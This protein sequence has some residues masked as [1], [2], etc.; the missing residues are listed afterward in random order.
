MNGFR[1]SLTKET[2]VIVQGISG[3]HGSFHAERM[4][5][6]GTNIIAGVD[7][8]HGGTKVSGVPVFGS[9]EDALSSAGKAQWSVVFVP[10]PFAKPACLEGLQA[11]L[12]L[13]IVTEGIPIHDTLAIAQE[14]EALGRRVI[15]PNCPG[16]AVPGEASLGVIPAKALKLGGVGVV[17][18]SGTLTYEIT[19]LLS[20]AGLGQRLLVGLGGDAVPCTSFEPI[21]EWMERDESVDSIV[22]IGEIG[23]D[24]EE[25]AADYIRARVTKPVA[26]YIAGSHAPLGTRMGHAGAIAS[27]G[28]GSAASKVAAL[29]DAEALVARFPWDIPRLLKPGEKV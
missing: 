9:V 14:A 21:L 27:A 22:L 25:R 16:L 7:P 10:A 5:K 29:E 12:N 26:A 3:R 8:G 24:F 4:R 28:S 15:G 18:R 23:G 17:S 13:V 19:S 11:G 1:L 6:Y 2:P 20:K